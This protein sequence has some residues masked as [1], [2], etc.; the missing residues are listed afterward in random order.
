VVSD[1]ALHL[2][3]HSLAQLTPEERRALL[4]ALGGQVVE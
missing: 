1:S 2:A 4:Q 3:L